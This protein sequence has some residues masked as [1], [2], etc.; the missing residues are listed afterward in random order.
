MGVSNAGLR[1]LSEICAQSSAIVHIC[2]FS[3]RKTKGQQLKGKTVSAL[4]HTFS[5]FSALF[6]TF[7]SEFFRIFPPGL[8]LRDK[9]FYYCFSSKRRKENKR[10]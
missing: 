6:H 7:F 4:F 2:A 10:E 8:S 3:Q 5:D 1:P 9:G